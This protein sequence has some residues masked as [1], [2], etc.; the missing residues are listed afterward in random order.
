MGTYAIHPSAMPGRMRFST[1]HDI[2]CPPM[3]TCNSPAEARAA[4]AEFTHQLAVRCR[5]C[6]LETLVLVDD[7]GGAGVYPRS[8]MV[9]MTETLA[10]AD[11]ANAGRPVKHQVTFPVLEP[12]PAPA[13][14]G[15]R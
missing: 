4:P 15:P 13:V 9:T 12:R 11:H 1:G 2:C 14:D 7:G 8:V 5:D 10:R 6:D 3:A